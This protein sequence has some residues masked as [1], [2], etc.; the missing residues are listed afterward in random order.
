MMRQLPRLPDNASADEKI[1]IIY[2][3]L[4]ELQMEMGGK[5]DADNSTSTE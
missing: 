5:S 1:R 2:D 3:W 4:Y